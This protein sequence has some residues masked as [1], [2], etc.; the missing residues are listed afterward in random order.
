MGRVESNASVDSLVATYQFEG[1]NISIDGVAQQN[2]ISASDFT[3]LVNISVENADG[4]SRTYQVDLTKYTGLPVVYLTTENN[5]AVESKEDYIN[6][7]VAIDGGRYFD[8]LPE[9]I[10]EI[11][12]RGN[13]T[14]A[15]HPKK[16]YQI[17]FE[18]KTEFLGM[19]EDK[20]WLFLAEYS[21]K[22]MLRNRTVFE[23]GHLSNLEYTTQGVYAEVFLNGL[24]NGTY[25]IT[26]KVEESNN[27]V[28]I[29]DEGY[30]LEIDQDWRIDPDDVFFYTDEFDGP[31]LVNIKEPPG[32]S[33][34]TPEYD[35]IRDYIND[36]EDA[37][38]G[39]YFTSDAWG[40]K[41]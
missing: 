15:L 18:N 33:Y 8:D 32:I 27:R 17:K 36:F 28:A 24:Y 2:G 1:T 6:G 40:Y 14:W 22:T 34:G 23:M 10:I 38:F 3:D 35:Y 13:S 7:T 29:G 25:N 39:E 31:G 41:R 37:L 9:S 26:Q 5:A 20:R 30:L 4:D 16:P 19:I 11:R 21:D 12:G